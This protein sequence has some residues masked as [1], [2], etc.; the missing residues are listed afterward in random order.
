MTMRTPLGKRA[1]FTTLVR[2]EFL[3]HRMLF[4][5]FPLL[6]T[7]VATLLYLYLFADAA[8]SGAIPAPWDYAVRSMTRGSN[9]LYLGA[10]YNLPL[11]MMMLCYWLTMLFYFLTTLQQQRKN[12]S[13]LFWNSLPVSDTQ[14]V[15][16]KLVAGL[17]C[18]HVVYI[19]CY[20]VLALFLM[21][22]SL[23]HYW[24]SGDGGLGAA[25]NAMVVPAKL[26]TLFS[27]LL[28]SLPLNVLWTLPVYAW[29]LLVSARA[30]E[31]P[32]VWAMAPIVLI[33][34]VELVAGGLLVSG[35]AQ[36]V[37][38]DA[39]LAHAMP[40]S[41]WDAAPDTGALA[42]Y[43]TT[44]PALELAGSMLLGAF[45]AYAAISLNRSDDL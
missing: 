18:C 17:V 41:L 25:W 6:G 12:R 43:R 21:L 2:R 22:V 34:L 33:V 23:G 36:S 19:A 29:C 14:T 15:L 20:V 8:V 30:R 5:S 26:P 40:A 44:Y 24:Y 45:F 4:V 9:E 13:V 37:M 28:L 7:A 16:S 38:L 3:E 11:G 10:M 35:E 39:V 31:L 42:S 32:F 27:T 1:V